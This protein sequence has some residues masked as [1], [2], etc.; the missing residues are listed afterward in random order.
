MS[1]VPEIFDTLS[2]GPAPEDASAVRQWLAAHPEGFSLYIGGGWRPSRVQQPR[3]PCLNPANGEELS[4]L[5]QSSAEDVDEAVKSGITEI[6]FV[7]SPGR[8]MLREYFR[9][10]EQMEALLQQ[11]GQG[12]PSSLR[13][14]S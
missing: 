2:Y 8:E 13:A 11:K 3:I 9:R 4:S 10:D 1:S 12:R 14:Y 7:L 6:I 5:T